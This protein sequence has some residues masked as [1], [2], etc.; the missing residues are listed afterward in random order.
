MGARDAIPTP[1]SL[2]HFHAV[3]G[4]KSQGLTTS[5]GWK[6][7]RPPARA[8]PTKFF[9]ISC[10]FWEN[11]TNF[12]LARHPLRVGGPPTG[13]PGSALDDPLSGKSWILDILTRVEIF[14]RGALNR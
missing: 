7:R 11:T 3:S 12:M 6:G 9:F 2:F 5:G 1:S 8:P 10:S 4:K 13:N 14:R